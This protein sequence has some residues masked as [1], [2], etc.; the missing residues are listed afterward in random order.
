MPAKKYHPFVSVCTPTFNRRPFIENAIKCYKNQ[1]YP[2]NRME[3]VVIDDGTDCVRDLFDN[4]GIVNLKY[5]YV[6]NV[7][8]TN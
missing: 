3:W 8:Y 5:F 6:K 1:D 2:T 7:N 4:A